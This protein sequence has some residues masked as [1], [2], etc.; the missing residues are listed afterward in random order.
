[1]LLEVCLLFVKLL[2]VYLGYLAAQLL[3]AGLFIGFHFTLAI[4]KIV[5]VKPPLARLLKVKARSNM[6]TPKL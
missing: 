2:K 4:R 6:T 3:L 1:V 5:A